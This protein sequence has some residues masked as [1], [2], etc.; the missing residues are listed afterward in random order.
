MKWAA[1][2]PKDGAFDFEGK[3]EEFFAL[4]DFYFGIFFSI[5]AVLSPF[6]NEFF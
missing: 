6:D 5:L 1:S 2:F 3:K 4:L